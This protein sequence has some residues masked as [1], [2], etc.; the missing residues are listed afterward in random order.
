MSD[1]DERS[2]SLFGEDVTPVPE[3][4]TIDVSGIVESGDSPYSRTRQAREEYPAP[5][6]W[7]VE[8]G[9]DR[10]L[11]D[12]AIELY[13]TGDDSAYSKVEIAEETGISRRTLMRRMD[14]HV[15]VGVFGTDDS[16]HYKQYYVQDSPVIRALVA[17]NEAVLVAYPDDPADLP[18]S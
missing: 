5:V 15:V 13:L 17:L 12:W 1:D 3:G 18:D 10:V 8:T 16:K 11:L 7:L 4:A 14:R 9:S 6:A 2:E